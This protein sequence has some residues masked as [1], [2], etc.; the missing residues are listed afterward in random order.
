MGHGVETRVTEEIYY[1]SNHNKLIRWTRV[2]HT[3]W[4]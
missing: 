4:Q 1:L 2:Q 3:Q